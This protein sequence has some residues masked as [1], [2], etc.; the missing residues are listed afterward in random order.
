LYKTFLF[1]LTIT[2][3][4][5]CKNESN[6][7]LVLKENG[8]LKLNYIGEQSISKIRFHVIKNKKK[9]FSFYNRKENSIYIHDY[10]TGDLINKIVLRKDGENAIT[11]PMYWIDYHIHNLD[12]IFISNVKN[13]F[14]INSLGEVIFKQTPNLNN[15]YFKINRPIFNQ[16]TNYSNGELSFETIQ[17]L[18]D[19]QDTVYLFRTFDFFNNKVIKDYIDIK[20]VVNDYDSVLKANNILF[21]EGGLDVLPKSIVKHDDFYIVSTAISDSISIFKKGILIDTYYVGNKKIKTATYQDYFNRKK[22]IK[23]DNYSAITDKLDQPP[24]FINMLSDGKYIYRFLSHG[25]R[26]N[27]LNLKIIYPEYIQNIIGGKEHVSLG[28]TLCVCNLETK[29][30]YTIPIKSS[31]IDIPLNSDNIFITS[32]GI[33][34][35]FE[36]KKSN[37]IDKS[38]KIY[39]LTE[40][41]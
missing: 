7:K 6:F 16:N 23:H 27:T 36:S 28:F 11:T 13:Y 35:P 22:I 5:S 4:I 14:L 25:T 34:F 1:I 8:I 30:S 41:K 10:K 19:K 26:A 3:F 24:F 20:D 37:T 40:I 9:L 31:E 38:Y 12:S 15:N 17:L 33:H 39:K 32:D 18:P 21:K 2:I 29:K